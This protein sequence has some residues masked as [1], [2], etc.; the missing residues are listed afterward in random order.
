V[1]RLLSVYATAAFLFLYAP[2]AVLGVFSVN[3]S[4]LIIWKGLS[5]SWY[6]RVFHNPALAEGTLNSIEIA[7]VATT[8]STI[9]G[10]LAAYGIWKKRSPWLTQSLYLSLLTPEIVT[11]ISLLA[12]FQFVFRF[13][14]LHLGMISVILAHISFS[15]AYVVI[16]ILARLRTIDVSLEEAALDLGA[17]EWQV[18]WRVTVPN[19]LPAI[20]AAALLC[21][22]VSFDDYVITSLVAGVNSETLP[23]IIYGMARKGISPDINALS[24]IIVC[25]LG[26]LILIA[27]RLERRRDA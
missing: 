19:L 10:T 14:H 6:E 16:V 5:L 1:R 27:G 26:T 3:A 8:I 9:F 23:M 7:L 13:L 18:F 22:T 25:G 17:N 4:R 24:M 20:V 12:L 15:L 2:L 11:G 21:F